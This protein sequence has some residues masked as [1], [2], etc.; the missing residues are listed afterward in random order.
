MQVAILQKN[1]WEEEE[2]GE[3]ATI[4]GLSGYI[5]LSPVEMP[6]TAEKPLKQ[7]QS[8]MRPVSS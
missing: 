6:L 2:D 3:E 7:H 1:E 8:A 4:C 5:N